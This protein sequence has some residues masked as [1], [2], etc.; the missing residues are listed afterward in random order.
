LYLIQRNAFERAF[1]DDEKR[2]S[3]LKWM[4]QREALVADEN[5]NDVF[6]RWVK[7]EDG[8]RPRYYCF[9]PVRLD[10]IEGQKGCES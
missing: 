9:D 5:R 6:T 2:V 4:R 10:T 8:G 3:A 1:K 7:S